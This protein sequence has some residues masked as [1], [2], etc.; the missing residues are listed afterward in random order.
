M[1]ESF[2]EEFHELADHT[3]FAQHLHHGQ[4]QICGSG[5]FP[6]RAGQPEAHDLRDQ[7]AHGLAQHH[8]FRLDATD[9]PAQHPEPVHHGGVGIGADQGIGIGDTFIVVPD[10]IAEVF[11]IDLM[12]NAGARRDHAE[13]IERSLTPAQEGIAFLVAFVFPGHV[14]VGGV[15]AAVIIDHHRMIYH[16]I[17]RRQRVDAVGIAAQVDHRLAHGGQIDD[18]GHAGKILHQH[19]GRAIGDFP[20][21]PAFL[22]P[23][24]DG[25]HVIRGHGPSIFVPKQIFQ[26]DLQRHRQAGYIAKSALRRLGQSEI[27]VALSI[28]LKGSLGIETVGCAAGQGTSPAVGAFQARPRAARVPFVG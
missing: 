13:I 21:G 12:A 28:N 18:G 10:N 15:G 25:A 17:H 7:H 2:A 14:G 4:Y 9:A 11:Q 19:P 27:C 20:V 22:D 16:Q 1:V 5:S 6:Q 26:Q 24:G 8:R 3:L 23:V